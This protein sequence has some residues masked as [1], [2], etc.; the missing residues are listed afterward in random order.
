MDSEDEDIKRLL[1]PE[2]ED[3]IDD[4]VVVPDDD[5]I[6]SDE[7]FPEY[8]PTTY[9]G[10]RAYVVKEDVQHGQYVSGHVIMNQCG[11]LLNRE[12]KGIIGSKYQKY[13]LQR[14][15][16]TICGDSI[17]L[18]FP[19]AMIFPSIFWSMVDKNGSIFGAIPSTFLK[20]GWN[21]GQ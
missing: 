18:L 16:S 12:H 21:F 8:F 6:P 17:P 14:I 5:D 20:T 9:A 3:N 10:D 11:S 4:F 7:V 15:A 19:E 2:E 1:H 13:Y